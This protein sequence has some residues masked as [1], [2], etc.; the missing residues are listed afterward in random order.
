MFEWMS[1]YTHRL[2][3]AGHFVIIICSQVLRLFYPPIVDKRR[4]SKSSS[5]HSIV[6]LADYSH[7]FQCCSSKD[8]YAPS[9]WTRSVSCSAPRTSV[10]LCTA[11][12]SKSR[13]TNIHYLKLC[14]L[15]EQVVL[16]NIVVITNNKCIDCFYL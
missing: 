12:S 13:Y 14:F 6:A 4:G 8:T 2:I 15:E 7:T 9:P 5:F 10:S 3:V 11:E 1:V 16:L